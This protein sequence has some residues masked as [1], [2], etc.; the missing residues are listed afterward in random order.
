MWIIKT[1]GALFAP[2]FTKSSFSAISVILPMG[3]CNLV[4]HIP[5]LKCGQHCFIWPLQITGSQSQ[6]ECGFFWWGWDHGLW[7]MQQSLLVT[8]P[9]RCLPHFFLLIIFLYC[10]PVFNLYDFCSDVYYLF[11][12]LALGLFF[13]PY[14]SFLR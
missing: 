7:M 5:P 4:T 13:P 3:D 14:P 1:L 12:L 11:I 2:L 8:I 9:N 10:F 6:E